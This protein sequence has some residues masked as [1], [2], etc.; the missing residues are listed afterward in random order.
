M[1]ASDIQT[2]QGLL[3]V[4]FL[5]VDQLE[6]PDSKNKEMLDQLKERILE[7]LSV[8]TSGLSYKVQ[9]RNDGH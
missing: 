1:D 2:L 4:Y 5:I 9:D 3:R 7:I 8:K 6:L